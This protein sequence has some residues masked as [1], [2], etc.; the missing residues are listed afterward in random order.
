VE[1][2][3]ADAGKLLAVLESRLAELQRRESILEDASGSDADSA[4]PRLVPTA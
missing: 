1:A 4:Q 2:R 3:Q